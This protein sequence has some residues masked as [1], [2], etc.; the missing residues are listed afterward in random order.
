MNHGHQCTK[1]LSPTY[2]ATPTAF[3][4][5]GRGH[6]RRRRGRRSLPSAPLVSA[7]SWRAVPSAS[8]GRV[9]GRPAGHDH[10]LVDADDVE[11]TELEVVVGEHAHFRQVEAR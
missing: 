10:F 6:A 1:R 8:E 9:L 7:V 11:L 4:R 3:H 5:G 2:R